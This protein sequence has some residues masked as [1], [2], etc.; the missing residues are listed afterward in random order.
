MRESTWHVVFSLQLEEYGMYSIEMARKEHL[1]HLVAASRVFQGLVVLLL[2]TFGPEKAH[3]EEGAGRLCDYCLFP[4]PDGG[5]FHAVA[6]EVVDAR[7]LKRRNTIVPKKNK[8]H[9][10]E[11]PLLLLTFNETNSNNQRIY[12]SVRTDNTP[13]PLPNICPLYRSVGTVPLLL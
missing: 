12:I 3:F 11:K 4:P 8:Q 7:L 5:V 6:L 2:V 1:G 9:F 13:L 10:N